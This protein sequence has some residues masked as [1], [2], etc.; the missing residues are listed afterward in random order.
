M[1]AM[2]SQ[3]KSWKRLIIRWTAAKGFAAI[4]LFVAITVT[5]E[6]LIIRSFMVMGL[7]DEY[8]WM[9]TLRFPYINRSVTFSVSPLFHILPLSVITVLLSSWAFLTKH[10]AF[11]PRRTQPTR[12]TSVKRHQPA[13][14]RRF[15]F[16]RKLGKQINRKMRK[17]GSSLKNVFP[18]VLFF[19]KLSRKLSFARAAVRSALIIF[20]VFV[21]LAFLAY[22]MAYPRW[23]HE[24]V[25]NLY[26]VNPSFRTFVIGTSEK[27]Q[28]LG[29]GFAPLGSAAKTINDALLRVAPSFRKSLQNI[30]ASFE[31]ISK[32][33]ITGKYLLVQNLAA[34]V[35]AF[36][37]L[38]YGKYFGSR[39]YQRR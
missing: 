19:S 2:T 32:L 26:R 39:R 20:A 22:T 23:I 28:S 11:V 16:I 10:V 7:T 37:A 15:K 29:K 18:R 36:A 30:G 27:L 25:V 12:K 3:E 14:R 4:L 33:D 35:C 31:P 1:I 5:L 9:E 13:S 8:T 17:M 34:W 24:A 38:V 21:C 6:F